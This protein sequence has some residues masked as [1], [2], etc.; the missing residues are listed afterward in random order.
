VTATVTTARRAMDDLLS[1]SASRRSVEEERAVLGAMMQAGAASDAP[2]AIRGWLKPRA[3]EKG[4][5]E[6]HFFRPV[7]QTI[8]L[9]IVA[10]MDAGQPYDALSVAASMDAAVMQRVG[11][12]P[13]LHTC[14]ESC[15]TVAHGPAYA[16]DLAGAT[17]LR[18]LGEA[19]AVQA[20]M[21]LNSSLHGAREVYDRV[22]ARL[23]AIE[24]PL[25]GAGPVA[26]SIDGQA[27]G[28]DD[29]VLEELDRLQ[30]LAENPELATAE[31]TTGWIDADRLLSPVVPGA[32]IIIAGRPGM[33]KTTT[34]IN[35]AAHLA[36]EKRL[37]VLFFS[38]EMSRLEIGLKALCLRA[39]IRTEDVKHGTLGDEG[40]TKAANQVGKD[41][42]APLDIDDTPGINTDYIDRE[43]A[44]FVRRHG[45]APVAFFVDHIGLLE[46]SSGRDIREKMEAITRRLKLL[47][48]KYGTVC[49]ALSQLNRGPESR[50]GGVPQMSDLRNSGSIEQD[51][52][53]VALLH[54]EDYYDKE[55]TRVGEMD[56]IVAKHRNGP[57]ETI[58][59]AAQLHMSRIV[60]MAIS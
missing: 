60:S 22:R 2:A 28:T 38:L 33:A 59:L 5:G 20:Q 31:F 47:A 1:E 48:K 45:R 8:W 44:A 19:A 13:Y 3:D 57:T 56:F 29:D 9:A 26:W 32:M 35:I 46:E 12:V 51:A 34:A 21:V 24:V 42:G 58:T 30:A 23:E 18:D 15:P 50:P 27:P 36:M 43:L 14:L 41:S 53:I 16:K 49:V 40:W 54:R 17:L 4:A 55:S 6:H 25:S 39:K 52:D 7:H 11:G 37:P 10:L